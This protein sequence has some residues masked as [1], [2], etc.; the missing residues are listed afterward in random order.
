LLR[1]G[2]VLEYVTLG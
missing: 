1:W 2:F